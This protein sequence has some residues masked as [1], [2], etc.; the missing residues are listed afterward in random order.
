M[1]KITDEKEVKEYIRKHKLNEFLP[2][3]KD[4]SII[5]FKKN[6]NITDNR[7]MDYLYYMFEGQ[8]KLPLTNENQKKDK[9]RKV[10]NVLNSPCF[11]GEFELIGVLERPRIITTIS[12]CKCVAIPV[13]VKKCKED[14]LK[15]YKF[16]RFMY[17]YLAEKILNKT[18]IDTKKRTQTKK[19]QF[20]EHI[21]KKSV[22][23]VI[24]NTNVKIYKDILTKKEIGD[25]FG[26]GERQI[27]KIIKEDFIDKNILERYNS[28]YIIKDE[29][30][31]KRIAG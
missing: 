9:D 24:D 25:L 19:M 21:L 29:E 31:L 13:N 2:N 8:A 3:N 14:L 26:V 4:I 15:S 22:C 20:A 11:I 17:K 30:E 10:L 5:I 1:D 28:G 16:L 7:P 23:T 6:E 27:Y 12:E 18:N